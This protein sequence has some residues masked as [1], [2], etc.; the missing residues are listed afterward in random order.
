M[1]PNK[2]FNVSDRLVIG[3]IAR[4]L[5][6]LLGREIS[7]ELQWLTV[8]NVGDAT[9]YFSTD[10][11]STN[12]APLAEN[13]VIT[14]VQNQFN[15]GKLS[16]ITAGAAQPLIVIEGRIHWEILGAATAFPAIT[17]TTSTTTTTTTTTTEAPTT[18]SAP[19]TT[20]A[21]QV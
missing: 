19:T 3:P 4:T 21:P 12:S 7:L 14:F 5:E 15:F 11:A 17:T 9:I 13:E 2:T 20:P 8:R 6:T 1:Y 16:F 10:T 18:T